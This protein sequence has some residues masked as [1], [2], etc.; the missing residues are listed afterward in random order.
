M[1][2][3]LVHIH[4]DAWL[5][6]VELLSVGFGKA[7]TNLGNV[8]QQHRRALGRGQNGQLGERFGAIA[9]PLVAD[10]PFS[11]GGGQLAAGQIQCFG[12]DA[13]GQLLMIEP[14]ALDGFIVQVHLDFPVPVA[15]ELRPGDAAGG[16]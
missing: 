15:G 10:Q 8:A 2:A 5:A 14:V 11:L 1:A 6:V 16:L 12:G 4:R 7:F 13:A 3:N 9:A